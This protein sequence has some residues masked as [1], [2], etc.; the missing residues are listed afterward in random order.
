MYPTLVALVPSLFSRRVFVKSVKIVSPS[1]LY[2]P[3]PQS[4][5][6]WSEGTIPEH[7]VRVLV[8]HETHHRSLYVTAEAPPPCSSLSPQCLLRR[9]LVLK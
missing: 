1:Y 7:Q 2:L 4:D 3:D 9:L 8:S 6:L 5:P